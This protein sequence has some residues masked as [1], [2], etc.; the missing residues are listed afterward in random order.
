MGKY[1]HTLQKRLCARHKLGA[2]QERARVHAPAGQQRLEVLDAHALH[3]FPA[4]RA[5]AC[6]SRHAAQAAAWRLPLCIVAWPP[7]SRVP[8]TQRQGCCTGS[9][10]AASRMVPAA[11]CSTRST[12]RNVTEPDPKAPGAQSR[13]RAW[14]APARLA[15]RAAG[16]RARCPAPARRAAVIL[17]MSHLA[18]ETPL[19]TLAPHSAQLPARPAPGC[20]R[21]AAQSYLTGACR[22]QVL[23][24]GHR[25]RAGQACTE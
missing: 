11:S 5:A 17:L 4:A 9:R 6:A 7:T 8:C 20:K 14:S 3:L 2:L 23:P 13:P 18:P 19:L 24:D 22:R 15:G 21:R 25:V 10:M 1:T 12:R 16:T